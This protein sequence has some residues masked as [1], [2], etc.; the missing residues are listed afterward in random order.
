[1]TQSI[2]NN[3]AIQNIAIGMVSIGTIVIISKYIHGSKGDDSYKDP[4]VTR[5]PTLTPTIPVTAC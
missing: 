3:T 1:M 2:L 5:I 4:I